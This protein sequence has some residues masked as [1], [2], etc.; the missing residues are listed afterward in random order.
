M[1]HPVCLAGPVCSSHLFGALG[2]GDTAAAVLWVGAHSGRKTRSMQYRNVP[3][4][5]D[6]QAWANSVDPD[7]TAS[8]STLFAIP[9]ACFGPVIL[10]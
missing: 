7:Q 8:E 4:F 9:S 1:H 2:H 3:K 10:W 6:S 5:S